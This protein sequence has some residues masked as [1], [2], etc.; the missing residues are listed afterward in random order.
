[1]NTQATGVYLTRRETEFL[2]LPVGDPFSGAAYGDKNMPFFIAP[3]VGA[4]AT[5]IGA[6]AAAGTMA[7]VGTAIG[8]TVVAV[9][10]IAA[11]AGTAMTVVGAVTGDQELMKIGAITGLAGG[12]VGM[13]AGGFSAMA[14]GGSFLDGVGGLGSAGVSMANDA[15]AS[16]AGLAPSLVEAGVTNADIAAGTA[17]F[18]T[19]SATTGTTGLAATQTAANISGGVSAP[20]AGGQSGVIANGASY[21]GTQA[22]APV[23]TNGILTSVGSGTGVVG[24]SLAPEIVTGLSQTAGTSIAEGGFFADMFKGLSTSDKVVLGTTALSALKGIGTSDSD[25]LARDKFEWEK[26]EKQRQVNNLNNVPK[27]SAWQFTKNDPSDKKAA[28]SAGMLQQ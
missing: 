17:E 11:V 16:T 21:A 6:A 24:Q 18:A 12:V 8:A 9:G 15:V 27:M 14:A 28:K 4:A 26:S 25:E 2:G 20:V 1:M 5:A 3:A 10:T 23:Y 7:A 19:Q 13:A 22:A